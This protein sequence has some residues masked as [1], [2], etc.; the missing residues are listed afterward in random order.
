MERYDNIFEMAAKYDSRK[1][2]YG[3]AHVLETEDGQ[4]I[5]YSYG[6]KVAAASRGAV[7]LFSGVSMSGSQ[8]TTRHIVEFVKQ[9]GAVDLW[10]DAKLGG[11]KFLRK[12]EAAGVIEVI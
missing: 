11:Q 8:T 7:T 2:F 3:K 6:H 12:Y 1:S 9:Y 10:E 4:A 5:L